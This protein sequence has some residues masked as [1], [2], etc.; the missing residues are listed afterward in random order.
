MKKIWCEVSA[1]K[2]M[3]ESRTASEIL[4]KPATARLEC[5]Y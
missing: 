3:A 5:K 2:P 1:V 4:D